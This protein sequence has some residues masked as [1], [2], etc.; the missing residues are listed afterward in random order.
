MYRHVNSCWQSWPDCRFKD[1]FLSKSALSTDA[2][3]SVCLICSPPGIGVRTTAEGNL[4]GSGL[5]PLQVVGFI[6]LIGLPAWF[7]KCYLGQIQS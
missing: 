1:F 2:H 3:S 6:P 4:L 5:R 7:E